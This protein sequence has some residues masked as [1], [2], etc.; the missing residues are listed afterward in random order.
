MEG[1]AVDKKSI[2]VVGATGTLGR[3]VVRKALDEGYD[4]RCVVRPRQNP[5]DFLR[6][7][8]AATV[9]ADLTNPASIPPALVG[10]HTIIDCATARPEESTQKVDWEGKV[11]LIQSAQ[12][13]GIQR[14]VFCSIH[15]CDKHNEVPLMN[16]KNCTEKF[17]KES[18]VD[19]TILRLCG[20]MQAIIGNYAVPILE[21]TQV[22]GTND[23]IRTA[24]LDTQDVARMVLAVLRS[25]DAVNK[26]L[27]LAGPQAYSTQEVISLCE[28]LAKAEAKVTSVP[29]WLLRLT[30]GFLK[31][32]QWAGDAADRLAFA[33]VLSSSESFDA[34]ME[35]TYKLLDIDPSSINTLEAY[36]QEYFDRI[37]AK[38]KEVGARSRPKSSTDLY[39]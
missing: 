29:V 32:F 5:A 16:I 21:E 3:Q 31:Q 10:I 6:D 7:W 2:L 13:M 26:T 9:Q 22:W 27:T 14:Y 4:V 20:F 17:L 23:T 35:E 12:A 37:L 8:G 28:K 1:K 39:V 34:P 30:R 19:Y 33:E 15:N 36:L 18:G 11:A 25:E 38:L 24:Y